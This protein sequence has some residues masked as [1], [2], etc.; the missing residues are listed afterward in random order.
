MG[1]RRFNITSGDFKDT[2]LSTT[3]QTALLVK[4]VL[5]GSNPQPTT[6]RQDARDEINSPG[7]KED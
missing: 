6:Q 3:E 7:T 1:G 5:S 2:L 4:R